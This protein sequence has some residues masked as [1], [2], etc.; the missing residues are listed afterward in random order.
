MI[1]KIWETELITTAWRS[2]DH[3]IARK[4][5]VGAAVVGQRG[6]VIGGCNIEHDFGTTFHAEEVA[7]MKAL[8]VG[9]K[10][11][12]HLLVVSDKNK[13]TPCGRCLDWIYQFG[14][15]QIKIGTQSNFEEPIQWYTLTELAPHYP[16][17]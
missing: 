4:T 12:H 10:N 15:S 17:K 13:F 7:I 3:A 16:Q 11:F 8:S 9:D 6:L 1:P 5:K 14:H 2:R